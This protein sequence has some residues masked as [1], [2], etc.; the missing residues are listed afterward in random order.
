MAVTWNPYKIQDFVDLCCVANISILV[1][2]ESLHGYYIH[3]ES[4][5]GHA[6]GSA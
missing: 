3:G 6:E 4:P 1:F 5:S 2:D